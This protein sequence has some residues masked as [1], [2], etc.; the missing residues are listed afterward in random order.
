VPPDSFSYKR[1]NV[2]LYIVND[3][4]H[5]IFDTDDDPDYWEAVS[6]EE[7]TQLIK[8]ISSVLRFLL[9]VKL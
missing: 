9:G 5:V 4:G 7:K 6:V 3:N 8:L 1:Y 2:R